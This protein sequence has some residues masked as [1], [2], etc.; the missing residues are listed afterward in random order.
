MQV[1]LVMA[2]AAPPPLDDFEF[3][4]VEWMPA[5]AQKDRPEWPG[6]FD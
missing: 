1:Q 3:L 5:T 2:A 6:V 4:T